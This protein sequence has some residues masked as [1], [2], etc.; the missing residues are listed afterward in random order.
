[1]A[2]GNNKQNR[3]S[4]SGR[5]ETNWGEVSNWVDDWIAVE[6]DGTIAAFSGKV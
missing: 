3:G 4:G 2:D 1:M 6:P 5:R